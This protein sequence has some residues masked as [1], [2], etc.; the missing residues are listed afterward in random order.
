MKNIN[1]EIM[2]G[3]PGSGKTHYTKEHENRHAGIY[4]VVLDELSD[5]RVYGKRHSMEELVQLGADKYYR[6]AQTILLDGP[7]FT[8]EHL[9]VA[10]HAVAQEYGVV[11]VTIHHWLEDRETCLKNDGGRR[12]V[13]SSITI[14]TA[15][16][17]RPNANWL[18]EQLAGN[19]VHVIK[20]VEHTVKLKPDWLRFWRPIKWHEDGM[21]Y[22]MSWCTGGCWNDCWG[23]SSP[24]SP[25]DPYDFKEL[26]ELLEKIAPNLT[27]LQYKRIQRECVSIH[28]SSERDYYGGVV[29]RAQWKCNLEKLYEILH[30]YGYAYT[31]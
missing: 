23:G 30:E 26:D 18:N 8:N 5:I 7:F 1:V 17:E 28:S 16:Y 6:Y 11:T 25:E 3:L 29:H 20:V 10:L 14:Q 12:E 2:M 4:A 19:D 27:F 15:T 9:R 24:V 31:P 21:M 13:P 22:S